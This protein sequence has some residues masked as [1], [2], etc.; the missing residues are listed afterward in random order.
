MQLYRCN[1]NQCCFIQ[2]T[3]LKR[4]YGAGDGHLE[5]WYWVFHTMCQET[6][7]RWPPR[8]VQWETCCFLSYMWGGVSSCP[9]HKV[10]SNPLKDSFLIVNT[11]MQF[12]Y[13][14]CIFSHTVL[15]FHFLLSAMGY[16]L[17]CGLHLYL[18]TDSINKEN[19]LT[20]KLPVLLYPFNT[21]S[22]KLTPSHYNQ[23]SKHE[24]HKYNTNAC[25]QT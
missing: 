22:G 21:D 11:C 24:P 12:D 13:A 3:L 8:C 16:K 2:P 1:P 10:I 6:T 7:N 17:H 20:E 14:L 25:L 5:S 18:P 4:Y 19:K 9:V 15:Y 23:A